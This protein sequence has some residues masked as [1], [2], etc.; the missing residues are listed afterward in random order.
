MCMA[1]RYP[2]ERDLLESLHKDLTASQLKYFELLKEQQHELVE[3]RQEEM[4]NLH[5]LLHT[6]QILQEHLEIMQNMQKSTSDETSNLYDAI[7]SMQRQVDIALADQEDAILSYAD[8]NKHLLFQ[9]L[10]DSRHYLQTAFTELETQ[11]HHLQIGLQTT[12]IL[13]NQTHSWWDSWQADCHDHLTTWNNTVADL[14]QSLMYLLTGVQEDTRSIQSNLD[15]AQ[16]HLLALMQPIQ[17]IR[18]WMIWLACFPKYSIILFK[19]L[20]YG[21]WMRTTLKN[22]LSS[23]T[24]IFMTGKH[25]SAADAFQCDKHFNEI[26]ALQMYFDLIKAEK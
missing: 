12:I 25:T 26:R 11:I 16:E 13:Q 10:T 3:W 15:I 1:L 14:N 6:Q 22:P 4:T 2:I 19:L 24:K 17:N 20:L 7:V 18:Y 8:S 9:M 23:P 5:E 21:Y